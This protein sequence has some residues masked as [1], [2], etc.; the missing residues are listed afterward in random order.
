M[1]T[2]LKLRG[3]VS[4]RSSRMKS[5]GGSEKIRLKPSKLARVLHV[6]RWYE[7]IRTHSRKRKKELFKLC[8]IKSRNNQSRSWPGFEAWNHHSSSFFFFN[9]VST[10]CSRWR[11]KREIKPLQNYWRNCFMTRFV[12]RRLQFS[13]HINS[14]YNLC[15]CPFFAILPN[16]ERQKKFQ[17]FANVQNLI[18]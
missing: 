11:S 9:D 1:L 3:C 5:V 13:V 16:L 8:E 14:T 15:V 2:S 4:C 17:H 12:S 7:S 10:S 6:H 18:K